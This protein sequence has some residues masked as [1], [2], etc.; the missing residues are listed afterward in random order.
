M[1]CWSIRSISPSMCSR[2]AADPTWAPRCSS[3]AAWTALKA[4][5]RI[6]V[7]VTDPMFMPEECRGTVITEGAPGRLPA[8]WTVLSCVAS[9]AEISSVLTAA[10]GHGWPPRA[11]ARWTLPLSV[12]TSTTAS[13]APLRVRAASAASWTTVAS[14]AL[15][16]K[17]SCSN[18]AGAWAARSA[19]LSRRARLEAVTMMEFSA[20]KRSSTTLWGVAASAAGCPGGTGAVGAARRRTAGPVTGARREAP[21]CMGTIHASRPPSRLVGR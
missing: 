5:G 18:S 10:T 4:R 12:V 17:A 14:S 21:G 8:L 1:R 2:R 9:P 20:P 6:E 16:L 7:T 15:R 13:S 11:P 19:P 3:A